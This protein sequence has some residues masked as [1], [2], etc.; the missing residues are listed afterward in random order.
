MKHK[1][2]FNGCDNHWDNALPFG[3]G[4]FGCM[5]FYEDK[6]LHIPMNHYEVYYNISNN[7]L[8]QDILAASTLCDELGKVHNDYLK[9]ANL[10]QPPK[11]EPF[12]HYRYTRE[13]QYGNPS[14]YISRSHPSTGELIFSFRDSF[15]PEKQKLSLFIE[16]AQGALVLENNEEKVQIDTIVARKDYIVNTVKQSANNIVSELTI[17]FPEYRDADAP[18]VAYQQQD[19]NTVSYTVTSMLSKEKSFIFC[20]VLGFLGAK[21]T[22]KKIEGNSAVL[23]LRDAETEFRVVTGIFTEWNYENLPKNALSQIAT[24]AK[25]IPTLLKEHKE[26]WRRFFERSSIVLPDKFLEKVYVLNQYALDCCSGKDGVMKH[27]SCGLNGLWD[28][29]RPTLWGSMWYWD[30][31]IQAAFAGVFSSNRLELAKV[32]SDGLLSY[33]G[34]AEKFAKDVHGLSGVATDYP[35]AFYYSCWSWCAQY[36]WFLYEYSLDEEYLRKEAYP[37]F[38]KLCEFTVG[39]FE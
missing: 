2:V 21:V 22:I 6:K 39:I 13:R 1:I 35:Y 23:S 26:Y 7:V 11:G 17:A 28:I 25:N 31:N 24:V 37:L 14:S 33:V 30:V 20:G 16:D 34:L 36:L 10:N 19:E 27:H 18:S 9:R 15:N 5:L 32:F 8:P 3:N 29:R 12:C 4:N 38:L